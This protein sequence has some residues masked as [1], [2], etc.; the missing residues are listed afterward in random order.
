MKASG[1]VLWRRALAVWLLIAA[2]ETLHGVLRAL[3]VAPA[4]GEAAA[5]RVGF[6]VASALVVAVAWITSAW[7]G[8]TTR[9]AQ[10]K[11]GL[12]WLL[13][14]FGFE[15]AVG[16]LRG[17]SWQRISAEFDPSQGGLMVIGLALMGLAPLL[18]AWLHAGATTD[19]R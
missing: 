3:F 2:V 7:L 14:M 9:A 4:I 19:T 12:L 1:S 17:F 6:V 18:G 13:L 16:R 15:L 8:A 10:L 11:V 5:Q